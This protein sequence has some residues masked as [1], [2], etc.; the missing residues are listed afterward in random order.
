M[1]DD[2]TFTRLIREYSPNMYRLSF[3]ILHSGADAEDAVSEAILKAY[4][5]LGTLRKPERFRAWIMQ[6]TANEAR[7]IYRKNMRITCMDSMEETLSATLQAAMPSFVDDRHELWDAVMKMELIYR[8]VII[9]YFY[10]SLSI[11]EIG[12]VLHIA[13][14]TVKS[15]LHRGKKQL[16]KELL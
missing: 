7:K 16:Q 8:E 3:G 6:I 10:E 2:E 4:E 15:R 11:K 9:L 12:Q 13:P 14:G 5:N 1:I